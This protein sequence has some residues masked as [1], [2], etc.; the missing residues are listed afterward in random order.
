MPKK[1][2]KRKQS[3]RKDASRIHQSL[4]VTPS[5]EAGVSDHFWSLEEVVGLLD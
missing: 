3:P 5:M 1:P 2:K 4:R